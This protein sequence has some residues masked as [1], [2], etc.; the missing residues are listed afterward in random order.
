[1]KDR[2]TRLLII[3]PH[4]D[5]G[6]MLVQQ[7]C[8]QSI[9]A[10]WDVHELLSC[11]DEYGTSRDAFKGKRIQKIRRQEMICA[12]KCYG[13]DDEGK[14]KLR[15]HWADYLDCHVP[16]NKSSVRRYK[17]FIE[18]INPDIIVGPDPFLQFDGH[19]DHINAG[20]NYYYALRS[21]KPETRP[22]LMLFCQSTKPDLYLKA[23][24]TGIIDRARL[25]HRSQF[26][27]FMVKMM[28]MMKYFYFPFVA[29]KIGF[30]YVQGFR[31]VT[32]KRSNH[33]L[34]GFTQH[35]LYHLLGRPGEE[36]ETLTPPHPEDL[37][38]IK[39]PKDPII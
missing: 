6:E 38:L 34:R 32:F 22:R 16:F 1:M 13:L 35:I 14:S 11:C 5:D 28:H 17:D 36:P 20:R 26:S 3:C 37:G 8:F 12:A 31:K 33:R 30:Y 18:R 7:L 23:K 4:P 29:I 15:L 10:G 21:M 24:R 39:N 2:R 19:P 9:E 27:P 25:C